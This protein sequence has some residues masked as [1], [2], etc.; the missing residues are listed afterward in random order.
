M[1]FFQ[2]FNATTKH[3]IFLFSD[4]TTPVG[5]WGEWED[6]FPCTATC[7]GGNQT[8]ARECKTL[9]PENGGINCETENEHFTETVAC[10]V[11]ACPSKQFFKEKVRF[12]AR[13]YGALVQA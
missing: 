7:G 1:L 4:V 5:E 6:F 2:Y 11:Q 3:I 10:N 12:Q 13:L 9:D 8:R